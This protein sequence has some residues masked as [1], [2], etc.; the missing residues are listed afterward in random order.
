MLSTRHA[1]SL[2]TQSQRGDLLRQLRTP[3]SEH[4]QRAIDIPRSL[5][6]TLGMQALSAAKNP[7]YFKK[8]PTATC[9]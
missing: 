5:M 7:L 4:E 3:D 8:M 1:T 2:E 9:G 6:N